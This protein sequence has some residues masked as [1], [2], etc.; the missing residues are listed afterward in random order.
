MALMAKQENKFLHSSLFSGC[1]IKGFHRMTQIMMP[2]SLLKGE[3]LQELQ[4]EK[5]TM[6][7]LLSEN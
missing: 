5:E 2:F 6:G 3:N 4:K 1:D 7:F